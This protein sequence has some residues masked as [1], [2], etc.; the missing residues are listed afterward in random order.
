MIFTLR[1]HDRRETL[2]RR[3]HEVKGLILAVLAGQFLS[4]RRR[5]RRNGWDRR[6][7]ASPIS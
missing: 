1:M 2:D 6:A 7:R 3:R 4:K 5:E